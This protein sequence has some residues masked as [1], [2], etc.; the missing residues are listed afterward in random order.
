VVA[1]RVAWAVVRNIFEISSM[2]TIG[3]MMGFGIC[4]P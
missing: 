1:S 3:E 2:E 4:T